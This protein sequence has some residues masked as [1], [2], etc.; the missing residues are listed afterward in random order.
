MRKGFD[1]LA[2]LA[3]DVVG[4]DPLAG[5]HVLFP[6]RRRDRTRSSTGDADGVVLWFKRLEKGAFRFPTYD[7]DRVA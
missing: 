2:Q 4:Q 7:A 5:H 6:S 3:R 1:S